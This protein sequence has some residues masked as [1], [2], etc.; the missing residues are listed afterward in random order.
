MPVV[1]EEG[2]AAGAL[3]GILIHPD[4]GKIEGFFL[5]H[6]GGRSEQLFLSTLDIRRWTNRVVIRSVDVLSPVE[7]RIR[8]QPLLQEGRPVIGQRMRTESGRSLGRCSDIQFDTSHYL[9]E[10]LF[11]RKFFRWDVPMPVSQVVEVR[12]DA[13]IMRD[14]TPITEKEELKPAMMPTLPEVA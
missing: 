5:Q 9:L 6:T 14:P 10:W 8:L 1:T 13:I 12:K 7:E 4:S 11:P 3:A 2:D